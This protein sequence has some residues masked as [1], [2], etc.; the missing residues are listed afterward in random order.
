[1]VFSDGFEEY[2]QRRI[3]QEIVQVVGR[4]RANRYPDRQFTI[5][6]VTPEDTDLS[7]L[8]DFGCKVTVKSAFEI[9]PEAGTETQCTRLQILN[10][11]QSLLSQGA[12]V[13]QKAIAN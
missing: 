8:S 9:T 3:N 2:Y 1:M 4:P 6:F 11:V 7:W 12:N 5:Y 10:A 13:T